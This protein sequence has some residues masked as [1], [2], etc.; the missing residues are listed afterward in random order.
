MGKEQA[1]E[2]SPNSRSHSRFLRICSLFGFLLTRSQ[3]HMDSVCPHFI[4]LMSNKNTWIDLNT[5][6]D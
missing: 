6:L 5:F 2:I 3:A 4:F 1:G